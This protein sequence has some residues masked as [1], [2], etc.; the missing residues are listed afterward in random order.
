MLKNSSGISLISL[1]LSLLTN[2]AKNKIEHGSR[3]SGI[4]PESVSVPFLKDRGLQ[5]S[6]SCVRLPGLRLSSAKLFAC[7]VLCINAVAKASTAQLG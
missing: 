1:V 3:P 5:M 6:R 4:L 7:G 2:D